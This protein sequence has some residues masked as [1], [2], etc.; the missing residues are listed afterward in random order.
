MGIHKKEEMKK[1]ERIQGK[2]LK[3]ITNQYSIHRDIDGNRNI[4]CRTENT[5]CNTDVVS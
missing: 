1:I 2:A 5:I 3:L 4:T